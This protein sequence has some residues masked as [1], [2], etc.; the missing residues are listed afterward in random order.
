MKKIITLIILLFAVM[1]SQQVISY[2][3]IIQ[4][5]E[6][7]NYFTVNKYYT[8]L[9]NATASTIYLYNNSIYKWYFGLYIKNNGKENTVSLYQG[10]ILTNSGTTN[11]FIS[12]NCMYSNSTIWTSYD[13]VSTNSGTL[14]NITYLS[15]NGEVYPYF[16]IMRTNTYYT[17]IVSNVGIDVQSNLAVKLYI[18][19]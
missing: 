4:S 8:V 12:Q 19:R 7:G 16:L 14:K 6:R 17:I 2:N 11:F 5:L 10:T 18:F 3:G 9:T 13:A 15:G 1:Y